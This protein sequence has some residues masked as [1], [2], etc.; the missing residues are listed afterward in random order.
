MDEERREAELE[1]HDST[2][3]MNEVVETFII[4]HRN[5]M[6]AKA[7]ELTRDM[8]AA[9]DL[10]QETI[11]RGITKFWQLKDRTKCKYWLITILVNQFSKDYK[12][13]KK[14]EYWTDED[15]AS[16]L[17]DGSSPETEYLS[18]ETNREIQKVIAGLDDFLKTPL[19]LFYF[20]KFSYKA[21]SEELDIPIGTVM[22]RICRGRKQ[23][24]NKIDS[25]IKYIN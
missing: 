8:D 12:R 6:S 15:I 18:H 4:P 17:I 1:T 16:H 23:V 24:K 2:T 20:K 19:Q 22:S 11:H 13:N 7:R 21:I 9:E 5:V 14:I 3:S 10:V 25:R